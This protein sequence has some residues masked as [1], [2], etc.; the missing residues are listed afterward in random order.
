MPVSPPYSG[1][2]L[3]TLTKLC[4][5]VRDVPEVRSFTGRES[6]SVK[7]GSCKAARD[8]QGTA[9]GPAKNIFKHD[10]TQLK[11]DL[12]IGTFLSLFAVYFLATHGHLTILSR[13][14]CNM[15]ISHVFTKCN[16]HSLVLRARRKVKSNFRLDIVI[17]LLRLVLLPPG[18]HPR[19]LGRRCAKHGRL[20]VLPRNVD[21]GRRVVVSCRLLKG[22][23]TPE[24]VHPATVV[25]I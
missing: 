23:K 7:R 3:W 8:C 9:V 4:I 5:A 17:R 16:N 14:R 11:H 12:E 19:C 10:M 21:G 15:A 20:H 13:L 25:Q 6:L 22:K 2:R 1:R 24:V 18:G